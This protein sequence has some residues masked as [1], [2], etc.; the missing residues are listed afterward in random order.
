MISIVVPT[1]ALVVAALSA[2]I[3]AFTYWRS[4]RTKAAE[5]LTSLHQAFFVDKTYKKVR[6]VL[7]DE[8]KLGASKLSELLQT[9]PDDFT[10]FLNFFELV[11][12]LRECRNLSAKDVEAL[13]GYYLTL[14]ANK[15]DLRSYINSR[16]FEHLDSLLTKRAKRPTI[17]G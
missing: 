1:L 4:T 17:G 11:A 13:P 12:Y 14:L 3:A 5:F 7:D 9:E 2:A 16:D 8:S 6:S 10:D 15:P